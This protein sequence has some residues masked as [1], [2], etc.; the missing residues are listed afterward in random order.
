MP[1]ALE[2]SNE[3]ALGSGSG[4]RLREPGRDA[5]LAA[6]RIYAT[7]ERA[8]RLTFASDHS[9]WQPFWPLFWIGFYSVVAWILMFATLRS[10]DRCMGRNEGG[11][12]W[13]R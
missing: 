13:G 4:L 1:E 2:R 12:P 8:S 9:V 11:S 5:A 7:T 6:L 3:N 10:F